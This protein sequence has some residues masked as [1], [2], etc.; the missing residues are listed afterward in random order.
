MGYVRRV[1]LR[2]LCDDLDCDWANVSEQKRFRQLRRACA[3]G[4]PDSEVAQA[5]ESVPTTACAAHPLVASFFSSFESDDPS[6]LR[7]SISGL[8]NPHWWKQKVSRWRGA[9][10]DSTLV[11]DDEA[12]LCAG[13]LR[14]SGEARD[15]YARFMSSVTRAGPEQYL[16]ADA[17]RRVQAVE[18]KV[19]RRDAWLEQLRLSVLVCLAAVD[20][21]GESQELHVP[22]PSPASTEDPLT[23]LVFTLIRVEDSSDELIELILQINDLDHERQYLALTAC[24]AARSVIEPVTDA[25]DVAAGKGTDQIWSVLVDGTLLRIASS[26]KESGRLPS[27]LCDSRPT[28]AIQAHYAPK[29]QIVDATVEGNAIRGL[30]GKWFVPTGNPDGLPT[31]PICKRA[32]DDLPDA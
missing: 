11:G 6:V 31:C 24:E 12:W 28:L 14:A 9:A 8:A 26:A 21:T 32:H 10:T 23:H 22:G 17:D 20:A 15:F 27:H 13:G 16:P 7:E 5:L 29:G 4:N 1:T 25:W 30:C 18:E 19:A 2:C 3:P